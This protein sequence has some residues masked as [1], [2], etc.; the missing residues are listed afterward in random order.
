MQ[1]DNIDSLSKRYWR[2]NYYGAGIKNKTF[3]NLSKYVF[4]RLKKLY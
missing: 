4:A 1:F 2:Y 3:L